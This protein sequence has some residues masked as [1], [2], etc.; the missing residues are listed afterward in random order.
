M[1]RK[2]SIL[3]GITCALLLLLVAIRY[4]PG[5]SQFDKNAIGFDWQTN[6]LSNLFTPKAINGVANLSRPWAIGGMIFLCV[7]FALFFIE[8]SKKIPQKRPSQIIRY[9][10]VAAMVFAFLAVTPY[11]DTMITL[12]STFALVSIFYITVFVFKSKLHAV[13]IVCVICLLVW[14]CCNYMYY[15]RTYL[16]LLPVMQKVGFAITTIWI[17]SLAYFT[18]RDDFQHIH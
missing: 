9:F 12:A 5:G 17:L 18:K 3:I 15:T 4:Y 10:G 16:E 1:L 13:K 8:F 14:Y 2:Y 11:H 7:S 6:Y